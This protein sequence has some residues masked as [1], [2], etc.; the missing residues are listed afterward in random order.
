MAHSNSETGTFY[1]KVAVRVG[2][3]PQLW[4]GGWRARRNTDEPAPCGRHG[5]PLVSAGASYAATVHV[6]ANC[7]AW[8][9][10][11]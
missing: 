10:G 11:S 8:S 5:G 7:I 4:S 3:R 2:G 9:L 6:P 1:Q